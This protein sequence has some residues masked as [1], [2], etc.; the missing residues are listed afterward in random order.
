MPELSGAQVLILSSIEWNAAW[1]RHQIF[2]SQFASAGHEVFFV[3]NTGLRQPGWRDLSR[4]WNR[5]RRLC[6][7]RAARPAVPRLHVVTPMILPPAGTAFRRL[8]AALFVPRL[9]ARLSALGLRPS[10]VV[11]AYLPNAATLDILDRLSPALIV[12]DCVD[13][14]HGAPGTPS[15]LVQSEQGLLDRCDLVLTTSHTLYADKVRRHPRVRELHHGASPDF[16][17]PLQSGRNYR[18]LCYYGTIWRALDY[19]SLRALAEAG[20]EVTL[21]GPQKDPPPPLPAGVSLQPPLDHRLLPKALGGQDV[22]LLPYADNEY[23]RGVLPAKI[24][25]CLATGLP[26]VA[27]PLPA[28]AAMGDAL[29][30]AKAPE[31]WVATV[32]SLPR[33]ESAQR[34]QARIRLAQEHSHA[35]CFARLQRELQEAKRPP[36]ADRQVASFCERP[37]TLARPPLISVVMPAYNSERTI[38]PAVDSIL[39]QT[40]KDLELVIVDDASSDSTAAILAS[41][42]DPRVRVISSQ[43]NL[44]PGAARRLGVSRARG[45]YIA[46]QDADDI[47]YPE[48]LAVQLGFMREH[49]LALCGTWSYIVH[50]DGTKSEFRQTAS[51]ETIKKCIV[52]S[53]MFIH[54]T[55]MFE[56][57]AY[58]AVGG[59]D[60]RRFFAEDYDLYLRMIK[61]YRAGNVP[62]ILAEYAAPDDDPDY[63]WR[64]TKATVSVRWNAILKYRYPLYNIIFTL[65][66]LIAML[67]PKKIK[68]MTK[69]YL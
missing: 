6:S 9:L 31:E 46:V 3:E 60:P 63:L 43:K 58:E 66:P 48:R 34:R 19:A 54:T 47:S 57:A 61:R 67:V 2:A 51:P 8:N 42:T 1:Q 69:Q 36:S 65:T 28:L 56:K 29:Y 41:V 37:T 38:L 22:L 23:N 11:I 39:G 15:D 44:G 10:P 64:E 5:A 24:Y 52:A 59:Y 16:F 12:Y 32:R 13:N 7:P 17:I 27:S 35:Q 18:R 53:N 14:F 30:T 40:C 49:K 33:T 26:V 45:E 55:V 50:Q 4:I 21:I 20:F 62:R 68:L 25:E